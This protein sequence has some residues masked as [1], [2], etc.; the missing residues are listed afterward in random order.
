[1]AANLRSLASEPRF[2]A[3][4]ELIRRQ[5]ELASDG[6][7]QLKF[8]GN[9]GCLAHAA[10]VRYG[11]IELEGRIKEACEAPRKRGQQPPEKPEE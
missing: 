5:K 6:A 7:A 10:G 2:A 4:V 8:A 1:M 3:V 9:H 11:M